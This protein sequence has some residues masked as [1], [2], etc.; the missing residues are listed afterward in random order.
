MFKNYL[1]IAFRNIVRQK[2]YSSINII[3]LAL[4]MACCILIY[5]YIQYE[6]SYDKFH[7]DYQD[8]YRVITRQEGNVYMGTDYWSTTP[9]LL[10]STMKNDFPEVIK[11]TRVKHRRGIIRYK[12]NRFN[13]VLTFVDPD[14]LDIF[15]FPIKSGDRHS[16]ISDPFTVLLTQEMAQKYFGEDDPVG[17]TL[18]FNNTFEFIV[19][20]VLENIPSNSHFHFDFLASIISLRTIVGGDWGARYLNRWRSADFHSYIKLQN[21]A[22]PEV[23]E[24]KL[25]AFKTKYE[26]NAS[27]NNF[28]LQPLSRIHLHSHLNFEMEANSYAWYLYLFSAIA[29]FIMLIGCFNYMSLATARSVQRAKEVGLR[30]VVGAAKR[31]LIRQFMSESMVFAG[32]AF[33]FAIALVSLFLPVFSTLMDRDIHFS[34]L[35]NY[36]I[37]LGVIGICL[38]IGLVAGSYPALYLA[39][40]RPVRMLKG[41]FLASSRKSIL[42]RNSLVIVQFIISIALIICTQVVYDQRDFIKNKDL[43]FQKEYILNVYIQDPL[44]RETS[45]VFKNEL[46]KHNKIEDV[47]LSSNIPVNIR[48]G[49]RFASWEGKIEEEESS[50]GVYRTSVDY[51]YFDFYGIEIVK[52]RPFSEDFPSDQNEAYI[53]NEAVA[54]YIG[55]DDP[56]GKRFGWSRRNLDGTVIGVI[57]DFHF[58]PLHM[59]IDGLAIKLNPA[60]NYLSLKIKPG[61][62]SETIAY[63]DEKW[64]EYS[65]EYP[66]SYTFLDDRIDQLYRTEQRLGK[67]F[68]YFTII[69]V[70]I[71]C[72]GLFAQASHKAQQ[73]TKEIGI[74]KVLGAS[75]SNI[76]LL[77]SREFVKW[78]LVAN[79]IAW[80]IAYFAMNKWLQNFAYRINI[81]WWTFLLAGAMALVIAILTVSYQAIRAATANPVEALRY[82]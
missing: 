51:N 3:G 39:S 10:A 69:A 28:Q 11:A 64:K 13:E 49:S 6:L 42:F 7:E 58:F 9:A 20:G 33:L 55:W 37:L 59:S 16:P 56:I 15:T 50:L 2:G 63:I 5:F 70:L 62:A 38:L 71:A 47:T 35:Q 61:A 74:R 14:F 46:L 82:E 43:G 29:F 76:L 72:L 44:L 24:A 30:K 65:P 57:K 22:K 12:A 4:G 18:L 79:I 66:F 1:K 78:V 60:G 45:Q 80:P 26:G 34:I 77:L 54:E 31:S 53:I 21:G 25:P 8:I 19:R 23:L 27:P 40:L 73:K 32:I 36:R 41:N 75:I 48:S 68:N 67:S 81:G 17:K 52:G